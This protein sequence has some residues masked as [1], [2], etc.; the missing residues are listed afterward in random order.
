[1][2]TPEQVREKT[3]KRFWSKIKFDELD[4]CWLWQRST[5]SEGYG[6]YWHKGKFIGAHRFV[7]TALLH[8]LDTKTVVCHRCD[9]TK[10]V[11]PNHLFT[12]TQAENIKDMIN[13]GRGDHLLYPINRPTFKLGHIPQSA[14]LKPSDIPLI[15]NR[16]AQGEQVSSIAKSYNVGTTAIY[17]IKNGQSWNCIP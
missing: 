2:I 15:K 3:N 12:G 10:C 7:Y 5:T 8:T 14:K 17:D 1:M 16:I 13:K 11:N 9:N 6:S 4:K